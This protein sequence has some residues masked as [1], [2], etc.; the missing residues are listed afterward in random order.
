MKIKIMCDS[1]ASLKEEYINENNIEV[2]SLNVLIDGVNYK[3]GKNITL[4]E[5]MEKFYAGARV[6]SSQP[7]PIEFQEAFNRAKQDGYTDVVCFTISSTGTG[8]SLLT[9]I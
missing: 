6:S 3:D 2:I 4:E 8:S 9:M 5:V 1:T 7:S